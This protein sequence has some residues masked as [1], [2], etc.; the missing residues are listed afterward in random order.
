M[1]FNTSGKKQKLTTNAEKQL[2]ASFIPVKATEQQE[3]KNWK[4]KK[5]LF[6]PLIH[7]GEKIV[8]P[9]S[10]KLVIFKHKLVSDPPS[11]YSFWQKHVSSKKSCFSIFESCIPAKKAQ[12]MKA[13]AQT[14]NCGFLA[15][16]ILLWQQ[17]RLTK[18]CKFKHWKVKKKISLNK[19]TIAFIT[20]WWKRMRRI[21]LPKGNNIRVLVHIFTTVRRNLK[22]ESEFSKFHRFVTTVTLSAKQFWSSKGKL[23]LMKGWIQI[24]QRAKLIAQK[25]FCQT[26]KG[27][28]YCLSNDFDQLLKAE[29]S[30]IL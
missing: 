27:F 14:K 6:G 22:W 3:C 12:K 15:I 30:K 20:I 26:F 4:V 11:L 10:A 23:Y 9:L 2:W 21:H 18:Q 19:Q 16:V 8:P 24:C 13:N 1:F 7:P 25:H 5:N 28:F 29:K 17:Q